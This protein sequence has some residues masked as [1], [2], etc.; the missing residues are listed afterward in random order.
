[1]KMPSHVHP[2]CFFRLSGSLF[3]TP[4]VP[5]YK[6]FKTAKT[7]ARTSYISVQR[8][9]FLVWNMIVQQV[10]TVSFSNRFLQEIIQKNHV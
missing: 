7:V 3:Y 9:Y 6:T 8:E 2:G 5:D 10:F 4:S 1:M